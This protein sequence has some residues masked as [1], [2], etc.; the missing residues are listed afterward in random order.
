L[1]LRKLEVMSNIESIGKLV[2]KWHGL[3]R[4]VMVIKKNTYHL[5]DM[6]GKTLPHTWHFDNLKMYYEQLE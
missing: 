1:I 5:Q 3:F 4:V 2:P 6:D